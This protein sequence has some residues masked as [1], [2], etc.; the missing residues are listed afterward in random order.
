MNHQIFFRDFTLNAC[1]HFV[2]SY[3]PKTIAGK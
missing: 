3:L 1:K 2:V